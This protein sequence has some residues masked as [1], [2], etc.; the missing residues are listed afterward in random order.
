MKNFFIMANNNVRVVFDRRKQVQKTGR[1]WLEACIYLKKRV[2]RYVKLAETTPEEWKMVAQSKFVQDALTKYEQVRGAMEVL[3]EPITLGVLNKHLGLGTRS[4]DAVEEEQK[5]DRSFLDFIADAMKKEKVSYGTMQH[6]LATLRALQRFGKIQRMSD[7]TVA[8]L[9]AFDKWLHETADRTD[10][11][12]HCYHKDVGMYARQA[13]QQGYIVHNPYNQV[14]F[15]RGK[16]KE[17]RPLT[18]EELKRV[19]EISLNKSLDRARDLFVFAAYTGLSY[20]DTKRFDFETMVEEH[21][22]IY[23]IDS[24]RL[25]TG[26]NFYTPILPP[27]LEVLKKYG[28]RLPHICNQ[29]LN[30]YLHAIE[31]LLHLNKPMTFHVARHSFATLVLSHDVP[32]ETVARMLGHS[33]IST[34]SIYAKPLHKTIERHAANLV[35]AIE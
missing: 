17:R 25:K 3:G 26:N 9:Y 19:R 21:D 1:G 13:Y 20:C 23:Y 34:T 24:R 32:I 16:S 27:A 30:N 22:G 7:L 5:G 4:K 15:P 10:A 8:N 31:K 29:R 11:C 18:E 6:K 35:S 33:K 12:V 2:R 14:H 28:N